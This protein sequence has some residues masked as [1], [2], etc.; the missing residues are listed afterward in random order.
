MERASGGSRRKVSA[1]G[2]GHR[3]NE[4]D[5]ALYRCRRRQRLM[6]QMSTAISTN[7]IAPTAVKTPAT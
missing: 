7:T 2:G 5:Q 4:S 6:N 3:R 1:N